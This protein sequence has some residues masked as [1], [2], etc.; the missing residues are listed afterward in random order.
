LINLVMNAADAIDAPDGMIA[1]TTGR[2]VFG[3]ADLAEPDL[4]IA[5]PAAG[6]YA[7]LTVSDTAPGMDAGTRARVFDPFFTTK[8]TV[9]GLGLAAVQGILRSH[10]GGVRLITAPGQGTTFTVY[11]PVTMKPLALRQEH[12]EPAPG[13]GTPPPA[14]PARWTGSGTVLVVDDD[15]SVR[16]AAARNLRRLGFTTMS[17]SNGLAA[18]EVFQAHRDEVTCVLLDRMMPKMDGVT[19][20]QELRS[21]APELCIIMM[22]GYNETEVVATI[23][24]GLMNSILYKPFTVEQLRE[25]LRKCL[26]PKSV[27]EPT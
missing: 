19:A 3:A 21:A 17:A 11:L 4:V 18:I 24:P 15:A 22:T 5:P 26:E 27:T 9:R 13:L 16:D 25:E 12:T 14:A 6:D 1:V 20:A 2:R 8:A 10:G 7:A 23:E